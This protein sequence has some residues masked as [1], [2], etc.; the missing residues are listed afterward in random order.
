M[1][2]LA[3]NLELATQ[4]NQATLQS[5]YTDPSLQVTVTSLKPGEIVSGCYSKTTWFFYVICGHGCLTK[6]CADS[7]GKTWTEY[8]IKPGSGV[9]IPR[10]TSYSLKNT[11]TEDLKYFSVTSPPTVSSCYVEC[12]DACGS[13]QVIR[14]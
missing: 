13:M 14:Q 11:T 2:C 6:T 1:N 9:T 5:L 3:V 8:E 4:T 10:N 7:C 12:T